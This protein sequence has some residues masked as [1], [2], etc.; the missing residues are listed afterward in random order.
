MSRPR[1]CGHFNNDEY[2]FWVE[3][4]YATVPFKLPRTIDAIGHR[5][6]FLQRRTSSSH[7]EALF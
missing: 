6:L 2:V 7:Q 4:H 5:S 3:F 1:R